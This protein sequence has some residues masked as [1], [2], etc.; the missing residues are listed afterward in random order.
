MST[1]AARLA[2]FQASMT[3]R[4]GPETAAA[5]AAAY[6]AA[7]TAGLVQG[8]VA[9]GEA[10]PDFTLPDV[11]L[12]DVVLPDV[13]LPNSAGAERALSNHGRPNDE[14]PNPDRTS[15]DRT[16]PVRP[17][18]VSP[19]PVSPSPVSPS[20]ASPS[21][22]SQS[23]G[24][25]GQVRSGRGRRVDTGRDGAGATHRLAEALAHGPVVLVFYRGLW[26]PFCAMTLRAMDAIR[27]QLEREG[28]TLLAAS[29]QDPRLARAAA[30]GLGLALTLL[31]DRG[32]EVAQR[33]RVAWPVPATMR[34]LYAKF[35]HNLAYENADDGRL[36]PMPAA[37]VIRPDGT[38]AAA[39]VDPRPSERMPPAEA[40]AAVRALRVP[41]RPAAEAAS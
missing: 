12:P 16:C 8:A 11:V 24:R 36:L 7:F 39:K 14:R 6:M 33:Y 1:L 20:L 31:H 34:Q 9:V 29:P 17:S 28:A 27:P 30:A 10:A 18:P 13:A 3:E 19:S 37:F 5:V 32:C 21:L 4:A 40:L 41:A 23:L 22:A 2:A 38:V 15:P 26:C 25:S 35:G